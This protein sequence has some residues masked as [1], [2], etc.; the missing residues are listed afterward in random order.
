MKFFRQNREA[1]RRD[2]LHTGSRKNSPASGHFL[3]CADAA[4]ISRR[5]DGKAQ[6]RFAGP[7][8]LNPPVVM[9]AQL[10]ERQNY[11]IT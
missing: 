4:A 7:I 5:D 2:L 1:A 11:E 10:R 6:C 3:L 9:T 8:E